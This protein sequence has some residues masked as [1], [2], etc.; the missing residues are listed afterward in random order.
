MEGF[1]EKV[2]LKVN[3]QRIEGH[4]FV[5]KEDWPVYLISLLLTTGVNNFQVSVLFIAIYLAAS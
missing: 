4:E 5:S 2:Y 1:L 3:F